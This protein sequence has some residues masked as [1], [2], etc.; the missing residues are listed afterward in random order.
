M[1]KYNL[2]TSIYPYALIG[3]TVF[4]VLNSV[5]IAR[6]GSAW[7]VDDWLIDYSGGFIRRGLSGEIVNAIT[8]VTGLQSD[9]VPILIYVCNQILMTVILFKLWCTARARVLFA[10]F[11]FSPWFLLYH[12]VHPSLGDRKEEIVLTLLLIQI[13][14]FF[15]QASSWIR[16]TQYWLSAALLLLSILLHEVG[17]IGVMFFVANYLCM[18]NSRWFANY[19][20]SLDIKN[21][22][23]HITVLAIAFL[24]FGFV[25]D[26]Q[27][28]AN[29]VATECSVYGTHRWFFVR[30]NAECPEVIN[31]L[32]F[33]NF[34]LHITIFNLID[35]FRFAGIF[36]LLIFSHLTF[37]FRCQKPIAIQVS[38]MSLNIVFILFLIAI[39]VLVL[40]LCGVALDVGRFIRFYLA[41]L[42]M[43]FYCW[44]RTQEYRSVDLYSR[45][46]LAASIFSSAVWSLGIE[47]LIS[48][49]IAGGVIA[50]GEKILKGM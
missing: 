39:F 27:G 15:S 7:F 21:I 19:K 20:V 37:M 5:K 34:K 1:S 6:Q 33:I 43:T 9:I 45:P 17:L 36:V 46:Y 4:L 42:S 13:L 23:L 30:N 47:D 14:S 8:G 38:N 25:I 2:R 12:V 44:S 50:L 18:R 49:G 35:N 24:V 28:D 16:L 11:V 31:S 41:A 40:I 10:L 22:L 29:L 3:Y 32:N 26:H 48:P